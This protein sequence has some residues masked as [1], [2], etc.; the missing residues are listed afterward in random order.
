MWGV[1]EEVVLGVVVEG[2]PVLVLQPLHRDGVAAKDR[3]IVAGRL[4]VIDGLIQ[5]VLQ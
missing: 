1:A 5:L 2:E 3:R 4:G